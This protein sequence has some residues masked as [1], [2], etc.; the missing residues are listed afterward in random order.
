MKRFTYIAFVMTAII[1]AACKAPKVDRSKAPMAAPAPKIQIGQYQMFTMENGLK[2]IVVENHKL[3]RVSYSINLDIDP[4]L[5]GAKAGYV[6]MAG[7]LMANGT[8]TKSKAQIDENVDFMGASLSTSANGIFGSCLKKHSDNF[9]QLM[10]DV[11]LNP[12]FPQ[13][14]MDKYSKQAISGLQNE[15]TDPDQISSKI[16]NML[17][18]GS[19]HPY[20]ETMTEESMGNIK[21]EDLVGYY[22]SYFKPDVAYLVIVGDINLEEAK[23]QSQKY[24]S[25]WQKGQV[26]SSKFPMPKAPEG[27]QVAFVPVPGA[28]QSVIDITYP[29]DLKPGTM[30]AIAASVLNNILGGSGFQTRL[31]QNLR[32]NK[33]YTYGSYSSIQPDDVVGFFSAGASVRNEVTDSSITQ[34]LYEMQRLVNEPVPDSTLQTVKNIMT[35]SFAR[36]LERPQT[37]ANFALNIQKYGLPKDYYETY[38]QKLSAITSADVQAIA[39]KVIKPSNAHITVVG[40]KEVA[41]KLA[42]FAASKKVDLLNPDGTPFMELRPAPNGL[43]A[44]TVLNNYINAIGGKDKLMAVKSFEQQGKM[45]M[46]PMSFDMNVKMKDNAKYAVNVMMGD[47]AVMERKFNGTKGFVAQMGQKQPMEP[48]DIDDVKREM[49]L[50]AELHYDQYKITPVL[51]G[52][53]KLEGED[54]YVVE[55]MNADGT[56][57]TDYFS[58]ASGLKLKTSSTE[59][60]GEESVTVETIYQNYKEVEGIKIPMQI[61]QNAGPQKFTITIDQYKIN[62][63]LEDKIF[64]VE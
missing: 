38:L 59:G 54:V 29:V 20:G 42:V 33:A 7:D 31:M 27:N 11:L 43:T 41:P 36:S 24:F 6:S 22:K 63:K 3:P 18:F 16:G 9:L 32:E 35:G 10:S 23:A 40:N 17:N 53:D 12:S 34:I 1:V 49:D 5:E 48:G 14:E 4:V 25:G 57:S 44:A 61:Q 55:L 28:V 26:K 37:I 51:K 13:D 60:E 47:M 2:V 21:R 8:T 39:K 56:T 50:L 30:D 15:K 52:I 45:S 64:V 19:T 62:P 46:G 58:V